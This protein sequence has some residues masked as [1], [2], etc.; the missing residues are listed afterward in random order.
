M[1]DPA[2]KAKHV[3]ETKGITGIPAMSL[4]N[5]AN[6]EHLKYIIDRYPG[7]PKLDGMLLFK[8]GKPKAIV[9]NTLKGNTGKHNFTFAH[10]LGHYFLNHPPSILRDGQSVIRCSAEDIEDAQKPREVEANKFAAELLMPEDRFRFDM[11]G[12]EIDFPLIRGLSNRYMVSKLACIIRILSFT[13]TPCIV[14]R[15]NPNGSF[16]YDASRAARG[17]LKNTKT[18]PSDTAAY[19]ALKRRW[20]DDDFV[21]CAAEKWLQ[22]SVPSNMIHE[23]THVH[24]DSGT[25]MTILKW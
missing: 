7:D 8:S 19:A 10:E 24:V 2:V 23:C 12:A 4:S 20:G 14:I 17:F 11:V 22:K 15:S 21:P 13:H 18:V 5:I 16:V 3:L 6:A 25:A 9:V 1:V